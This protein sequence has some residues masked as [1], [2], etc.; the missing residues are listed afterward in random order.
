ML[1]SGVACA[2]GLCGQ[3]HFSWQDACFNNPG[4]PFCP[5]HEYAVRKTGPKKDGASGNAGTAAGPFKPRP[6]SV[7]PSIIVVG[8]M[9][10]RFA[11]PG[12][13][14]VARF[15][16]AKLSAFSLSRGLIA[17]LG[18]GLDGAALQKIFEG[19]SGVEQVALS[20]RGDQVVI[21]V[22]GGAQLCPRRVSKRAGRPRG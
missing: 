2:A 16:P 20:V 1:V 7:T 4:A 14:A 10:W 6:E 5:G 18:A 9:N 12:A 13:D 8:G 19:L 21:M 22:T 15:R 11:D 3:H 17:Q